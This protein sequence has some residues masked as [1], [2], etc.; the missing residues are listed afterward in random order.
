MKIITSITDQVINVLQ[1]EDTAEIRGNIWCGRNAGLPE[2]L[3]MID[4]S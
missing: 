2:V 3:K 1:V 4:E